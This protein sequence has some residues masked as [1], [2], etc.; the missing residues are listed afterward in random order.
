ML[1]YAAVAWAHAIEK[2]EIEEALRKLN[3]FAIA[4]VPRSTPTRAMELI[5]DIFPLHLHHKKEGLAAFMRLKD[6]LDLPWDGVYPNLTYSVSHRRFWSY[7]AHDANLLTERTSDHCQAQTPTLGFTLD[8]S[9]FVD[10][11]NSQGLLAMNVYTDGSR[12]N[13]KVGSGVYM[14]SDQVTITEKYRISDHATVYQA[15]QFAVKQAALI[16]DSQKSIIPRLT[17]ANLAHSYNGP[18][19]STGMIY[20]SSHGT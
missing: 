9:S 3:R 4:K 8:T 16:R 20:P 19:P 13:D 5:L 11:E 7:T 2:D 18:P 10:M 17:R 14:F 15:E 6:Q 12:L 1:S